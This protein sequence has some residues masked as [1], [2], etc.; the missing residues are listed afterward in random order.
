MVSS[1]V[2]PVIDVQ[3][4]NFKELWPAMVVA[5]KTSSFVALDTELSGL[6]NRKSLLAE[7]IEDRYKAVCHAARSRS[8]LS[9]GIACYKKLD[10]KAADT[11]LVQV[12]NLTLLCSEEYI[13][14]PQ[15]V[16]FLV[17]HGFDFNKQYA[18]GIP[19]C[20]G[21]NKGALDDQGV[22]IRALF[23][24]LLRARKPLVLHNGL[25]DMVFLYQS[26][27]AHL[28]DRLANFTS[29]LS[30]MFP[31]GIYD[32][33]YVT[34]FE[35]RLT[36]S[37]LEYAYK[38]CKLDNSRSVTSGGSGPHFH[39]EFCQYPGHMS[40]YVDYRV[41]PAV[42]S[43]EGRTEIC[44]HFSGFG[45]CTNGNQ[46]PLSHDT[47][48]IIL[49]DEKG[50]GEKRKK[51]K[52]HREKKK[53][54]GKAAEG[55]CVF[56][57]APESKIP[58]MEVDPEETP[59]DQQGAERAPERRPLTDSEGNTQPNEGE[60]MNTGSE[61]NQVCDDNTDFRNLAPVSTND[62]DTNTKINT[63]DGIESQA[64]DARG[65]KCSDPTPKN[66]VQTKKADPGTHRAGFDAFMTGYIFAHSCTVIK[67][68]GVGAGEK[69]PQKEEEQSWL[70]TC[71]NKVYLSRKTA[72]LNVVKSTF[73]KSSKA[74]VQKM[75][76]VWGRRV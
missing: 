37:Y 56:D 9:L 58:H 53:G 43:A 76:I 67:K 10:D 34:E 39:V 61:G 49:Q 31:A 14:E 11:Y 33:K 65:E 8:I 24:E 30:E 35:L 45:W 29:D 36:A 27:Y 7:S 73:S 50:T 23:T 48:L 13:I 70:P 20:K 21:N 16:Q 74:H 44:E 63:N 62:D 60:A 41:C 66:G 51:R 38:K 19:Y 42:A 52:R 4:D 55:S 22:H 2:V 57:G 3:N 71:V 69:E 26:F 28:P 17:Q 1:L 68:E 32:T 18:H 75:E 12:Y 59:E 25:I 64:E 6:G 40:S 5:M 54:G 15:S 46:C 47:D 72:P